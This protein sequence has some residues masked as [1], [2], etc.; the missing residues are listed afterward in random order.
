MNLKINMNNLGRCYELSFKYL[1]SH[2][3]WQLV[4]G[5]ITSKWYPYQTID[6]AWCIKDDT[7]YDVIYKEEFPIQ[8]YKGLF[9]CEVEKIYSYDEAMQKYEKSGH[10]GCW[11]EVKEL[12][13]SKY[14][15]KD[16]NLKNKYR[17]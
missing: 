9:N 4:H 10:C 8:L 5:Y 16:G 6:H 1:I 7:I 2:P 14:Y 12:N 17:K 15:D 11:H 3:D 13:D